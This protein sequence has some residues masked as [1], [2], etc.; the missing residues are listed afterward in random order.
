MSFSR[1]LSE[2]NRAKDNVHIGDAIV[3][4]CKA[5]AADIAAQIT[6]GLR[7]LPGLPILYD[8]LDWPHHVGLACFPK[9]TKT[10]LRKD[11][12]DGRNPDMLHKK[13][14]ARSFPSDWSSPRSP[15]IFG[16]F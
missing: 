9:W 11:S 3:A 12:I 16:G 13:I 7:Q 4:L 10:K 8:S 15:Y 6:K 2:V 1:A 5:S 14:S